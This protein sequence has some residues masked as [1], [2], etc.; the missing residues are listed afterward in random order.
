MVR[1]STPATATVTR[2]GAVRLGRSRLLGVAAA[3]VAASAVLVLALG[4]LTP[5]AALPSSAGA[6]PA[7]CADAREL[8]APSPGLGD[9]DPGRLLACSDRDHRILTIHNRTPVVWVLGD[10]SVRGVVSRAGGVSGLLSSYAARSG[11]GLLVAPGASVS[12]S[13]GPGTLRPRP[14]REA[15]RLHLALTAIV[16]AQDAAEATLPPRAPRSLVRSAALTCALA[17]SGTDEGWSLI[18]QESLDHAASTAGCAHA[19]RAASSRAAADGWRLPPLV[20][21]AG[22]SAGRE[23]SAQRSRTA[24]DWFEAAGG[25]SW[26]GV[27]RPV[28][29]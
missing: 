26:G 11:R 4:S 22:S 13:P 24:E 20:E 5:L 10:A 1:R 6:A 18:E 19:W 8:L 14:D 3:A 7:A 28:R 21:L 27:E 23:A 25:W 15:T 2:R 16:E 9:P 12:V 29:T 17:L